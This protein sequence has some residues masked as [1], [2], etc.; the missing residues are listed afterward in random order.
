MINKFLFFTCFVNLVLTTPK[1][2]YRKFKP[3]QLPKKHVM[4]IFY[5]SC[6]SGNLS[7]TVEFFPYS[8]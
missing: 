6:I 1:Y 2:Q 7:F 8:S 3:T 4:L 5:N